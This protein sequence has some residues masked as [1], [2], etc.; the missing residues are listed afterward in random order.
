MVP[1]YKCIVLV[2]G[3]KNLISWFVILLWYLTI[4]WS[5]YFT[6]SSIPGFTCW[7]RC[8]RSRIRLQP[9]PCWIVDMLNEICHRMMYWAM[10][11]SS[12]FFYL[13]RFEMYLIKYENDYIYRVS[14]KSVD[15]KHSLVLT[16]MLRFKP[17]S[18]FVERYHSVVSCLLNMEDLI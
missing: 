9:R 1:I 14:R 11:K 7:K 15:L 18:Q 6:F 4:I 12:Q 3:L 8:L 10:I 5:L 17:S 13:I 16:K 2:L